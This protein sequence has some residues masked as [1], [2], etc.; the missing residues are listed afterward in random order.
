MLGRHG[1]TVSMGTVQHESQQKLPVTH[2]A[3]GYSE[4]HEFIH[5]Y[6]IILLLENCLKTMSSHLLP[7][8][9]T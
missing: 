5:L 2:V 9:G 7:K 1:V 6:N 8:D 3:Q 4:I